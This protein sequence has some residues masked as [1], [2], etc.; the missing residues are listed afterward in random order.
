MMDKHEEPTIKLQ[1]QRDLHNTRP[2]YVAADVHS[3]LKT[4]SHDTNIPM[5]RIIDKLL[6]HGLEYIEVI[7]LDGSEGS[8]K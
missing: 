6:V 4:L 7:G 5:A 3:A 2:V 8:D 1:K